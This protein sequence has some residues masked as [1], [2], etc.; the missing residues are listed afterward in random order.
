[1]YIFN[2]YTFLADS[3]IDKLTNIKL[4]YLPPN[5]TAEIPPNDSGI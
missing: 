4:H 2:A 5:T 1:M 3:V